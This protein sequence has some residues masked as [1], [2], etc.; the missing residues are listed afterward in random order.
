MLLIQSLDNFGLVIR[1]S[2]GQSEARYIDPPEVAYSVAYGTVLHVA[3]PSVPGMLPPHNAARPTITK[4][5]NAYS[6]MS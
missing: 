1:S 6:T 2:H 5:R 4:T 3:T